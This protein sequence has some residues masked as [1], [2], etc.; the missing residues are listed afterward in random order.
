MDVVP[1]GDVCRKFPFNI[2]STM[3]QPLLSFLSRLYS[4]ATNHI[5]SENTRRFAFTCLSLCCVAFSGHFASGQLT[6]AET[7]QVQAEVQPS[8]ELKAPTLADLEKQDT[9]IEATEVCRL[10]LKIEFPR[11]SNSAVSRLRADISQGVYSDYA[12][13]QIRSRRRKSSPKISVPVGGNRYRVWYGYSSKIRAAVLATAAAQA[14]QITETPSKVAQVTYEETQTGTA[15][16]NGKYPHRESWWTVGKRYPDRAAMV[17]HLSS[18]QHK[19]VFAT[20]WLATLT[21]E[22]LHSLHSDEHENKVQW[23]FAVRANE[24]SQSAGLNED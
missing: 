16:T 13:S 18:G 2:D 3:S 23:K 1:I 15:T 8:S 11:T 4:H 24:I 9:Q 20:D 7:L 14:P 5:V 19:G 12:I 17:K 10:V 22:E 6:E 21:R